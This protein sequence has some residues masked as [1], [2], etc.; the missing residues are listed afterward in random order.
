[1]ECKS[2]ADLRIENEE[3]QSQLNELKKRISDMQED[4]LDDSDDDTVLARKDTPFEKKIKKLSSSQDMKKILE[5]ELIFIGIDEGIKCVCGK[6]ADAVHVYFN[7]KTENIIPVGE[8]CRKK[9]GLT[10]I[11]YNVGKIVDSVPLRNEYVNNLLKHNHTIIGDAVNY[12]NNNVFEKEQ[13]SR[14]VKVISFIMKFSPEHS[15]ELATQL[16]YYSIKERQHRMDPKCT[17]KCNIGAVCC[18]EDRT[19]EMLKC[20]ETFRPYCSKCGRFICRG[21][22][23]DE[24]LFL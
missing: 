11:S 1:M 12:I 2:C 21:C 4:S 10:D 24:N 8:K 19:I 18:C 3:L 15:I 20:D 13:L 23:D 17:C 16:Q 7:Y 6:M 22:D 9:Y 5:S 14:I